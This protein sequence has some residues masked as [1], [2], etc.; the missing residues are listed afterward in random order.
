MRVSR[1]K[2]KLFDPGEYATFKLKDVTQLGLVTGFVGQGSG[3]VVLSTLDNKEI[4]LHWKKLKR[5]VLK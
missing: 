4:K 2:K 1:P 3:V 5:V